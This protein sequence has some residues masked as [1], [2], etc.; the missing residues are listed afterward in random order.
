MLVVELLY[1]FLRHA[2]VGADFFA[3][4]LLGD[5]LIPHVLLE[6]LIGDALCRCGLLERFHGLQLHVLAHLVQALDEVG[7]A[8]DAEVFTFIEQ[9]LLID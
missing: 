1:F 7:I 3:D 8:G 9:K 5:D 4:H 6:V 2:E